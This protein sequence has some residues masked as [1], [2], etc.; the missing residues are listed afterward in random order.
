MSI[1]RSPREIEELLDRLDDAL[2]DGAHEHDIESKS[3]ISIELCEH[4]RSRLDDEQRS[5][6]DAAISYWKDRRDNDKRLKHL[7]R[8]GNRREAYI[9]AGAANTVDAC[10][11][12]LVWSALNANTGLSI[13]AAEYLVDAAAGA[14]LSRAQIERSF[15]VALPGLLQQPKRE[16]G[17]RFIFPGRER[18]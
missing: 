6:L 12:Q 7:T 9:N 2:A 18:E 13:L 11:N 8:I 15:E 1:A 17:D 14:G 4:I 3:R 16:K 5:A 10:A